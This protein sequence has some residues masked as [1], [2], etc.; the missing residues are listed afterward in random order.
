MVKS[1]WS[2]ADVIETI[3][4]DLFHILLVNAVVLNQVDYIYSSF[5]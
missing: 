1:W 3:Y 2:I 5:W 4:S